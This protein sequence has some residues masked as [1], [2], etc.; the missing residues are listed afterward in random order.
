M[1]K[2]IFKQDLQCFNEFSIKLLHFI[3]QVVSNQV[4]CFNFW[5]F[6]MA[7]DIILYRV[8]E[9][10]ERSFLPKDMLDEQVGERFTRLDGKVMIII[11]TPSHHHVEI[12]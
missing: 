12:L 11:E 1:S 6:S 7:L 9:S 4:R 3:F 8:Y 2:L 5:F 10:A